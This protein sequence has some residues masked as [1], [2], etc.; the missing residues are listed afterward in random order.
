MTDISPAARRRTPATARQVE[1]AGK[2]IARNIV[3]IT[4]T[5]VNAALAGDIKAAEWV[6]SRAFP[7]TRLLSFELPAI[8]TAADGEAAIGAVLA[9]VAG[10][11]ISAEE[12][13]RIV[14]IIK[15]KVETQHA[16]LVEERLEALE[17]A[18]NAKTITGRRLA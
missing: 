7:K 10:S 2:A 4:N 17:A 8:N 6:A 13:D 5:M 12:A 18:G 14:S 11:K 3:A 16:R 1:V 9:A 15:T